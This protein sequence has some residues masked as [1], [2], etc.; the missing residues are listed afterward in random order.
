MPN[1]NGNPY[2]KTL[3]TDPTAIDSMLTDFPWQVT[4]FADSDILARC[5]TTAS[6]L[7]LAFS[8]SGSLLD[9]ERENQVLSNNPVYWV[10]IPSISAVVATDI[11]V[12]YGNLYND[13]IELTDSDNT[14][15]SFFK[16]VWHMADPSTSFLDSSG[17]S[18]T[19]TETSGTIPLSSTS[20][21]GGYS[22]DFEAGD[23]EYGAISDNTSLSIGNNDYHVTGYLRPETVS[24]F[25]VWA[26]KGWSQV[27]NTT[28]AEFAAWY[29]GTSSR[30]MFSAIN[31]GVTSVEVNSGV[32][33]SI[34]TWYRYDGWHDAGANQIGISI[35]LSSPVTA[36]FSSS[37]VNDGNQPFVIGASVSQSLYFDGLIDEVRVSKGIVRSADWRKAEHLNMTA[38]DKETSYGSEVDDQ[39]APPSGVYSLVVD[40]IRMWWDWQ[41]EEYYGKDGPDVVVLY[42]FAPDDTWIWN[43]GA[44]DSGN[45]AVG[46]GD[47]TTLPD[48][49]D[50]YTNL[51]GSDPTTFA[52]PSDINANY[53]YCLESLGFV[54][55]DPVIPDG[56][57]S[58]D[59]DGIT[60]DFVI[61][62]AFPDPNNAS[63]N[64]EAEQ[65]YLLSSGS[66]W[67]WFD[68][69]EGYFPAAWT[70]DEPLTSLPDFTDTDWLDLYDP[71]AVLDNPLDGC[72]EIVTG[73]LGFTYAPPSVTSVE[74]VGDTSDDWHTASN[75]EPEEVPTNET[76]VLIDN[77]ADLVI[78]D[79]AECNSIYI[80][81]DYTGTVTINDILT[82]T[83]YFQYR[84]AIIQTPITI[85]GLVFGDGKIRHSSGRIVVT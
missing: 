62:I 71:D 39:D 42:Y 28:N 37:G 83:E 26:S 15:D 23:T 11:Q 64:N 65:L 41:A 12:E 68:I 78:D 19:L 82:I 20:A 6:R 34:N 43:H 49:T 29:N 73:L 4:P 53:V 7:N 54:Y 22:R 1:F 58:F 84:D 5:E 35:N 76:D 10:R 63:Y 46:N 13:D 32:S 67:L 44:G 48:F 52:N 57:V 72:G 69:G 31:G 2:R 77:A 66:A 21:I 27:E 9:F 14:W 61:S 56:V 51:S 40:G 81:S 74:W 25:P 36:A 8:Q 16:G 80:T 55:N 59:F 24:G 75:W 50:T 38:G 33:A 45:W 60:L 17:N 3:S 47:A 85:S 18:N 79:P 30:W 70:P